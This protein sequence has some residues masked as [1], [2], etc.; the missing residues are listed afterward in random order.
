MIVKSKKDGK[1]CFVVCQIGPSDS[2]ARIQADWVFECILKPVFEQKFADYE[3]IRADKIN[4]PGLIDVQIIDY[5]L[6]SDLVIAD[7]TGLNPNVFYEIG[8]RHVINR[9]IVH[10]NAVGEAIP[11]DVSLFRSVQYS[12]RRPSDLELAKLEISSAIEL[13]IDLDHVVD[14]PV[15]HA[16]GRIIFDE[17]ATPR[18]K[19]LENQ[20]DNIGQRLEK[21]EAMGH[22]RSA[23]SVLSSLFD[24]TMIRVAP[25]MMAN[26]DVIDFLHRNYHKEFT[27]VMSFYNK[28]GGGFYKISFNR[29]KDDGLVEKVLLILRSNGYDYEFI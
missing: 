3:L 16:R 10:I 6:N 25:C 7:I 11:F 18:E 9:P 14:N 28:E 8:I 21:I 29:P 12:I 24:R 2:D 23:S 15:T 20:I 1:T 26:G 13:A 17:Y 22:S 5:L 4:A 19:I 27:E